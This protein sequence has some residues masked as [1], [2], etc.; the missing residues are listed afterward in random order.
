MDIE[1]LPLNPIDIVEEVIY[2]KNGVSAE[3][4]SMSWWQIYR[5]N[6]VNIDYILLGQKT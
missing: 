4:M 1:N 3:L 6:G 5:Q 2:E